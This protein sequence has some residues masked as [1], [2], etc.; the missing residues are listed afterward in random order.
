MTYAVEMGKRA[1][2]YI[3][4]FI[5]IGAGIRKLI[6]RIPRQTGRKEIA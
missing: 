3:A 1:M 2:I 4:T 5:K 6:R